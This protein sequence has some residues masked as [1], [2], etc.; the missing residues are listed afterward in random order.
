MAYVYQVSFQIEENQ[1]GQLQIGASLERTLGY[2]KT[3][4]PNQDGFISARALRSVNVEGPIRL[5]IESAWETWS[6]FLVHQDS[7][8]VE[9]KILREFHPH[10]QVENL[11]TAVYDDV[12]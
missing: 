10:V 2:L 8:L 3:L 1:M 6:D 11:T 4:L 5:I 7:S 9:Q 12:A